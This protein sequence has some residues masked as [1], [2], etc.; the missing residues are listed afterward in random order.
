MIN[1]LNIC[2]DGFFPALGFGGKLSDGRVSHGFFMNGSPSNPNCKGLPGIM[3][4]Y[5]NS[6]HSSE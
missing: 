3:Q 5:H 4:A 1:K 2:A 6:V